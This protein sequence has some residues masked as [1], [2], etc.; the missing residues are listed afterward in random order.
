MRYFLKLVLTAIILAGLSGQVAAAGPIAADALSLPEFK[1]VFTSGG[2]KLLLSDSPEMVPEDGILYQDRVEGDI[3]LFFYHVN[4]TK[5]A[6]QMTVV[7]EN[8]GPKA[9]NVAVSQYGLGGPGYDWMAVGKEAMTAYLTGGEKYRLRI[10][11]GGSVLLSTDIGDIAMLPNMLIN[12]I[13]DFSVDQPVTVKVMMQPLTADS[14][15]FAR[16]AKVL[17]A[18]EVHLRGTFS[19]ANRL[20]VPLKA[21]DPLVHGAVAL[22]L[23][24]NKVDGYLKGMDATDGSQVVNYGNYGVVYRVVLS[25]KGKVRFGCYLTPAGGDYAGAVGVRYRGADHGPVAMPQDATSF[26]SG[27]GDFALVGFFDG[28]Q[29]LSLVFSPPGGSNMPVK[30]IIVPEYYY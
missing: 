15:E 23:A 11:P 2:G 26:G 30:L 28:S 18:D 6:K 10:S 25:S 16:K 4:A 24:D 5:T 13:Y 3:R 17:E 8:N 20:V 9:A 1:A 14:R 7:L 19:G 27:H 22:T 12:G 21:Y 29:P